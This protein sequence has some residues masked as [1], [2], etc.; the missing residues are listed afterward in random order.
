MKLTP[1][2]FLFG[3]NYHIV[4]L[5]AIKLSG[6][7][8]QYLTKITQPVEQIDGNKLEFSILF[9]RY[10]QILNCVSPPTI[11]SKWTNT[12]SK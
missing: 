7:K 3:Y 6:N 4:D 1:Q 10:V 2:I 9:N 11:D 5:N 8:S 12:F